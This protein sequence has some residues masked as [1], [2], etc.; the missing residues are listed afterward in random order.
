V[1]PQSRS[2]KSIEEKPHRSGG[3]SDGAWYQRGE[4]SRPRCLIAIHTISRSSDPACEGATLSTFEVEFANQPVSII[5]EV[6]KR[7]FEP[8]E[9]VTSEERV[10][11]LQLQPVDEF[12]LPLDAVLG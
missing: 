11:A 10:N 6:S 3:A 12:A 4:V 2:S 7:L 1:P 5:N 9:K 8:R